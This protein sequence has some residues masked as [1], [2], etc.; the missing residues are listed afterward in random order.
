MPLRKLRILGTEWNEIQLAKL[1][2]LQQ[3]VAPTEDIRF[4]PIFTKV[5]VEYKF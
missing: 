5:N 3:E 2:R 4:T 1:S